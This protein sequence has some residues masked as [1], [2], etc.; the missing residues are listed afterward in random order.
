KDDECMTSEKTVESKFNNAGDVVD[1]DTIAD[2]ENVSMSIVVHML[3]DLV[4]EQDGKR[5][6]IN[7]EK[8][9]KL[10]SFNGDH[11]GIEY[12]VESADVI[13]ENIL[14]EYSK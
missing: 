5:K 6:G 3:S 11:V 7:S 4:K 13:K 8:Y 2:Q 10:F 12:D 14:G 1:E 9:V